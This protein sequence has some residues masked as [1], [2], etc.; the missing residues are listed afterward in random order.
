[1]SPGCASRATGLELRVLPPEQFHR[2]LHVRVGDGLGLAFDPQSF[3][4][5]HLK[6]RRGLD[7]GG[8][9]QRLAAAKLDFLDVRV[10]DHGDFLFVHR[11]AIR[12]ADELALGLGLD[13]GLVF[14]G[15]QLARRLARA[16]PGQRRL[17]LEILRD[18]VKGF[19][20]GLRVHFHPHQFFARGQIF[21]GDIHK[22]SLVSEPRSLRE[23]RQFRQW[24]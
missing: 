17:F 12:I 3:V 9:L 6:F 20:H 10:A 22:N 23:S 24:F 16:E 13:V 1:M 21:N 19:V 14:F 11:L 5:G 7:G 18:G 8:K 15:H 2:A 4:I